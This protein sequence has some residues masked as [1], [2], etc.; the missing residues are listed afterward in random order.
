MSSG[1]ANAVKIIS[2]ADWSILL[3]GGGGDEYSKINA[4][5]NGNYWNRHYG[6]APTCFS[7]LTGLQITQARTF[8][9]ETFASGCSPIVTGNGYVFQGFGSS[10]SAP[11][12]GHKWYAWDEAG[13]PLWSF[14]NASNACNPL[15]IA[16]DRLYALEGGDALLYCFENAQ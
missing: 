5:M 7:G 4:F 10:G 9:G 6:G 15:A 13:N 3:S 8:G 12:N 14:Q 1:A 16:Y 2:T 11:D